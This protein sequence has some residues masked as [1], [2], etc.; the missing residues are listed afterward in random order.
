[1]VLFDLRPRCWRIVQKQ[2]PDNH[3]CRGISQAERDR[4][5][6]KAT[7]TGGPV[8]VSE[9]VLVSTAPSSA[10][11]HGCLRA[12]FPPKQA[13]QYRRKSQ[14]ARHTGADVPLHLGQ[15]CAKASLDMLGLASFQ[16]GGREWLNHAWAWRAIVP[17]LNAAHITPEQRNWWT[18]VMVSSPGPRGMA[19]Q[20]HASLL[21]AY[22][23]LGGRGW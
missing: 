4:F 2:R 6:G 18:E 11:L 15:H 14:P 12:L 20:L 10:P 7:R 19:N 1:M 8:V 5:H 21:E 3:F 13:L 9:A 16:A 23:G 22:W 17:R